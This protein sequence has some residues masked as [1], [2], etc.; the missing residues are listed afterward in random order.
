MTIDEFTREALRLDPTR[1][2]NLAREL[3]ASL[4]DLPEREI[5]QL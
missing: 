3:L 4:D 5:E 2:A 1:Q